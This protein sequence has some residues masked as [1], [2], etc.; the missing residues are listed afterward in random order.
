MS[1]Q[2]GFINWSRRIYEVSQGRVGSLHGQVPE[3]PLL[4]LYAVPLLVVI[5]KVEQL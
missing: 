3:D 5:R 2:T 4:G 1:E